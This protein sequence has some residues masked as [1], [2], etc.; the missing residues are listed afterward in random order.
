[1][2]RYSI[3]DEMLYGTVDKV[4]IST[5]AFSG[6]G[7]GSTKDAQRTDLSHWN[8]QKKAPAK[9]S[10][11]NRGG[12]LPT[13]FYVVSYVGK[14]KHFG[15]CARLDQTITSLLH[16]DVTAPLGVKVTDRNGFLIH[17]EGPK[18]SDGCIVPAGKPALKKV[19]AAL[20][21]SKSTV[22]LEVHSE[23]V[24]MDKFEGGRDTSN[25]A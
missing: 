25:I 1:M 20:K 12:P 23:G 10:Y 21:N 11:E 6:G 22:L 18:G 4:S 9:F 8:T 24:R 5:R 13:G 17:G 14:Y 16:V 7:R 19:L 3:T 2:L 15:E